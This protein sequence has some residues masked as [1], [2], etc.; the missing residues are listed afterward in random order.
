MDVA[1]QAFD[2]SVTAFSVSDSSPVAGDAITLNATVTNDSSATVSSSVAELKYYR[3]TDAT[4]DATDTEVGV[5]DSISALAAAATSA[6]TATDSPST[7]G[8]YFYG[9]CV[10][11]TGDSDTSN[12]CSAGVEVV[13]SGDFDLS[14][15]AF[16][17]SDSSVFAG[18]AITLNATVGN[19]S[20]ATASSPVA[21]LKYYRSTDATIDA[22]DTEV[23]V[24][25]SIGV[26]AAAATS[27]QTATDSPTTVGT[28]YYGACVMST[29]DSDTTNDCSA[30]VEVAVAEGFDLSVTTFSVSDT[31]I[32]AGD[33]ITLNAT[34]TNDSSATV[35]S[36]FVTLRYYRSTD[37]TISASDT[38][39]GVKTVGKLAP[40]ARKSGASGDSP[41]TAGTYYYGACV[42]GTGDIDTSNNCSAGVQVVVTPRDFDL[43][44]TAFSVS[45]TAVVAGQAITLNATVGNDSSAMHSSLRGALLRYYRSADATIDATDT[46]VGVADS[47]SALAAAATSAQTA[48]D[49]PSTAGTYYYGACVVGAGDSD[50]SNNCSAGVEVVVSGDFDLSVTTFSVDPLSVVAGAEVTFAATVS[51]D[52]SATASSPVAELKYYR[53]TDATIDATDTEVGV[54]DSIGALAAAATSAQTATDSPPLAG[55]YFYGACIVAVGDNDTSNDCSAGVQVDVSGEFDL[56]VTTFSVSDTSPFAGEL[57]TVS[58]TA[59]NASS[60]T[61]SSPGNATAVQFL[62]SN[63][64]T[65]ELGDTGIGVE[66]LGALAPGETSEKTRLAGGNAGTFYYGAC[67]WVSRQ[68]SSADSDTSNNCSAGVQVILVQRDFDLSVSA[69]SVSKSSVVEGEAITLSATVGNDSSAMHSSPAELKYYRSTDATLY[70]AT[71]TEVGTA[72]SIDSVAPGATSAQTATDNPSTAGT[73]YYY[74]CVAGPSGSRDSDTLNNCSAGV[75]VVVIEDFDLSATAFSVNKSSAFI[76]ERLTFSVTIGLA[77]SDPSSGYRL[78]YYRSDDATI[79]TSDEA[80]NG[81]VL[82][83]AGDLRPS[84]TVGHSYAPLAP[85][86]HAGPGINY[87]GACVVGYDSNG[88]HDL[89]DTDTSNNCSPG[90]R[91]DIL[92]RSFD[93]SVPAFSVSDSSAFEGQEITLSATVGN[94]SS[95]PESS[96]VATLYYYRSTDATISTGDTYLALDSISELAAGA[97]ESE[98]STDRPSTA[99]TYY[100]GACVDATGEIG[101]SDNCSASV[102]VD[103]VPRDFDLSVTASVSESSVL[104]GDTFTLSATVGNASSAMH[105]SYAGT[106]RYY[107]SIGATITSTDTDLGYDDSIS[108]LAAAATET[109]TASVSAPSSIGTYYYGACVESVDDSDTSNDCSAG[110]RV[111]V[112]R[113]F[114]LSVTTFSVSDSSVAAGD[115][116]TFSATVGNDSSATHPS[117]VVALNYYI[118]TDSTITADDGL[119]A[120]NSMRIG[121]LAAGGTSNETA[122]TPISASSTAS[123]YYFGACIS[124]LSTTFDGDSDTSNNCSAGVRV[125]F[126]ASSP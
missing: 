56:S 88:W 31:S 36:P 26:L 52:S 97:T 18:E 14:V 110:V 35:S 58:A 7:A 85:A 60:A 79:T 17:V 39:V 23:G 10:V 66:P 68:A 45:L 72:D 126:T 9:A 3:S 86:R 94:H 77:S 51:N 111:D 37:S 123:T 41:S 33:T 50:T 112:V 47:I 107:R 32:V 49:S 12:N 117:P 103:V 70:F 8:T 104:P 109:E 83:I 57:F 108:A 67:I 5:A 105:P 119:W 121:A 61:A 54:A 124:G 53:S 27:T 89:V 28:Y 96:P 11:G 64:S 48:T 95:A 74:V 30:G 13:V 93:L 76:D 43:S 125:D 38:Y 46:E 71:D 21:E 16:T 114:D 87:F 81:V 102:R 2:L 44:V 78:R 20:A 25:D 63:D 98:T 101:E 106:V 42:G 19:D 100:Y 99:G 6:Q 82:P 22:T 120:V 4:I 84:G 116:I 113:G 65:I 118:S 62:V 75:E 90:V 1:A 40:G 24:A 34:A 15:T 92:A 115:T 73:Y 69:F 91:V 122:S 55:T 29:G 59:T 80:I